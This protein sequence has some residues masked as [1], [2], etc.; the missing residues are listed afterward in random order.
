MVNVRAG[1]SSAPASGLSTVRTTGMNRPSTMALPYPYRLSSR[2]ERSAAARRYGFLVRLQQRAPAGPA[3]VEAGLR[4]EQRA[5]RRGQDDQRQRQVG[6]MR[7]GA[8]A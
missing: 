3:D 2:A 4:A 7:N 5:A 6:G 1:T 8:G